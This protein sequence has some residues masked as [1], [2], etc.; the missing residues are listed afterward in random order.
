MTASSN[1]KGEWIRLILRLVLGGLFLW[2]GIAKLKNPIEFA[3]AI[4]NFEII[5]DPFAAVFALFIPWVEIVAALAVMSGLAGRGGAAV[6]TLSLAVFTIAI[7]SAWMRGLDISC[8]CFGG[9]G[10]IN[11]PRKMIENFAL[12]ALGA[13]VWFWWTGAR[14]AG[15]VTSHS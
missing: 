14:D 7:A 11:Y 12:L 15:R 1:A 9:S 8:G 6:L 13:G 5:G 10:P 3:D 4:R 2:S